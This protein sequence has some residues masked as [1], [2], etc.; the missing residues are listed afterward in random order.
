M[1]SEFMTNKIQLKTQS[2][3]A[4]GDR[5]NRQDM[6]TDNCIPTDDTQSDL[7]AKTCRRRT[8]FRLLLMLGLAGFAALSNAVTPP[9]G[10]DYGNGNVALGGNALFNLNVTLA[11]ENTAI[12]YLALYSA[13]TCQNNTAVGS[14][15]LFSATTGFAN[16]AIGDE[17]LFYTTTGSN[18]TAVGQ[19]ALNNNTTGGDNTAVGVDALYA[20]TT[21][22]ANTASGFAA[23]FSNTT[24]FQNTADGYSALYSN[25]TGANNTAVG[26]RAVYSN[27]TGINDTGDGLQ[28]LF[29][30]TTGSQN[31]ASGEEAL[32][33]N[34]TGNN[35]VA[36]GAS[37]LLNSTT[38]SGNIAVGYSAGINL[39]TG[40][41][42][43][44]IGNSGVAGES[45]KIRL[46]TSGAQTAA[47]VAGV[48]GV[49]V[50]GG[51]AV[52]VNTS[53]QLGVKGSSAR[54][55]EAIQPMGDQ[56]DAIL[57]LRPVSFRYKKALDP[58][59]QPQ[60]GLIAEEVAKIDRDLI[61]TDEN[62]KPFSVRYEEV[63]AMLLNEFLKEHRKVEQQKTRTIEQQ[64]EIEA[65]QA[66]LK[67]QAA[68]IQKVSEQV[69]SGPAITRL[70]AAT[71]IPSSFER[72]VDIHVVDTGMREDPHRV[73][74]VE[75]MRLHDRD[76]VSFGSLQEQELMHAHLADD[77]CEERHR[78]FNHR[79]KPDKPADPRIHFLD[80]N[81]RVT[82]AE[83]VHPATRLDR[84]C[85]S[86]RGAANVVHLRLLDPVH[87]GPSIVSHC[88]ATEVM[89]WYPIL[90]VDLKYSPSAATRPL[91]PRRSK[92]PL[93]TAAHH[94][95]VQFARTF[96]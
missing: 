73:S 30:N 25:T 28:A 49:V 69:P 85:H 87:H 33:S 7:A 50:T 14:T 38:G 64:V 54:F 86:L 90:S 78:Q 75:L 31:T 83:H 91:P 70:A 89:S 71:A 72:D 8:L 95:H 36:D 6:K 57:S 41:N 88:V 4:G 67:E 10:G 79:V 18:N 84:I 77:P 23:L 22:G 11:S 17:A 63:N 80:R 34:S 76:A 56:S 2:P 37:A 81:R 66:A 68:Q 24:G 9:P 20:N 82:A 35:N 53:G 5:N 51:Q 27:S 42:N 96:C 39:T 26:F 44:D 74:R 19:L 93:G 45:G 16:T 43:I 48:R 1:F 15:A 94:R 55:K 13:T 92:A 47:F 59:A 12:G 61:V 60:F 58:K 40:S 52:V 3:P 46:G 21:G 32:F 65:L 62:G 29:Y